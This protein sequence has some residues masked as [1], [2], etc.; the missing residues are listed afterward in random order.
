MEKKKVKIRDKKALALNI[1]SG[2][3]GF[4]IL[5]MIVSFI[6]RI[7]SPQKLQSE[8]TNKIDFIVVTPPLQ[9][10]IMNACG[11]DGI[12]KKLKG[13]LNSNKYNVAGVGNLLSIAEKSYIK[14][15]FIDSK[16]LD[17]AT[18][19]GINE[20]MIKTSQNNSVNQAVSVVI[21]S[22]YLMLK[23]FRGNK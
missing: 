23:P 3:F 15:N 2:C 19:L 1:F 11:T 7:V 8:P 9:I 18:E 16:T 13:F 17:L 20:S 6:F 22:D 21:G 14:C 12:A 5:L 10:N 4:V